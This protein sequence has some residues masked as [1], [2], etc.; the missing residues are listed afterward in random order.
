M[1]KKPTQ[2]W[3]VYSFGVVL[4]EMLTG[5]SPAIHLATSETN[6][7]T[8]VRET[9]EE[10]KPISEILDLH[11]CTEISIL[12]SEF[13]EALQVALLCTEPSPEERPTM[14]LVSHSL[15]QI[16]RKLEICVSE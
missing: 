11:L 12:Q 16:G 1:K 2:K 5:R 10:R 13:M 14:S 6:L 3:D 9:V 7:A 4:L 8:W 15:E